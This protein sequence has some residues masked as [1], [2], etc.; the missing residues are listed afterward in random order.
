MKEKGVPSV[1][2]KPKVEQY[3]SSLEKNKTSHTHIASEGNRYLTD[4]EED[5]LYEFIRLLL[6]MGHGIGQTKNLVVSLMQLSM[7]TSQIFCVMPLPC[8]FLIVF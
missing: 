6:L 1:V 7:L 3:V 5:W 4:S 2:V 8:T